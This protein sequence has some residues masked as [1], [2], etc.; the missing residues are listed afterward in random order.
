MYTQIRAQCLLT[1]GPK[2]VWFQE[3][4]RELDFTNYTTTNGKMKLTIMTITNYLDTWTKSIL[5][6]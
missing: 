1:T 5:A 3:K 4:E 6:M 2:N